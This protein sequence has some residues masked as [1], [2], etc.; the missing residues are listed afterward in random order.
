MSNDTE[1]L[2][3]SVREVAAALGISVPTVWS[4]IRS[5]AMASVRIGNRCLVTETELQRVLVE[6]CPIPPANAR[7]AAFRQARE[8]MVASG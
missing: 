5:G 1:R 6:G 3:W 8:A 2:A 7:S 4:L